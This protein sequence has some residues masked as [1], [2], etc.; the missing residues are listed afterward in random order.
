MII[1]SGLVIAVL[2]ATVLWQPRWL[3]SLAGQVQ[4]GAVYFVET[5]QPQVALTIDDG[6][7]DST[8]KAILSVLD[9]NEAKATF[10]MIGNYVPGHEAVL[11]RITAA[12]HELGNHMS[13][14]E[15]SVRLPSAEF[16][17]DLLATEKT[18]SP[19]GPLQWLRPGMGWYNAAMVATAQRHGYRLALGSVFPYDTHLPWASFAS[20][21]ILTKVKPGDVIVL[22]DGDHNRGDRTV[23]VL[24]QI[25]PALKDQGLEVVTLSELVTE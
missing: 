24:E 17:T 10:F 9:Q 1:L 20:W 19:Y 8:T 14:D 2:I 5:N 16:E 15:A 18:L 23:K 21:F 25:L 6:P 22:H 13:A 3:L 11:E 4:P 7:H 12:G